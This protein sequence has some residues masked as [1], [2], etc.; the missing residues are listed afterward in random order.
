MMLH[1][2]DHR[3]GTSSNLSWDKEQN[4]LL[5]TFVII[6]YL[7]RHSCTVL[8]FYFILYSNAV[9]LNP[10]FSLPLSY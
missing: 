3:M 10:S 5:G 7:A 2:I 1:T 6:T 8:P 9:I 4:G